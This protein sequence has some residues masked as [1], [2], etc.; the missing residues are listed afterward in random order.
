MERK[1]DGGQTSSGSDD[2]GYM[3]TFSKGF[4]PWFVYFGQGMTNFGKNPSG[5]LTQSFIASS[6]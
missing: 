1:T 2:W 5:F 4:D 3:L 6:A